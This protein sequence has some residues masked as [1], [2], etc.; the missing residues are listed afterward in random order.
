MDE[1]EDNKIDFFSPGTVIAFVCAFIGDLGFILIVP[2]YVMGVV[3]LAILLPQSRGFLAKLVL[4][5]VFILP[6]PTLFLGSMLAVVLSNKFLRFVAEQAA[7]VAVTVA[8]GGAGAAAEGAVAAEEAG[9]VAATVGEEAAEGAAAAGRAGEAARA[10]EGAGEAGEEAAEETETAADK[11]RKVSN[12]INDNDQLPDEEN[13][14]DEDEMADRNEGN[15]VDYL[16]EDLLERAQPIE[17]N[18]QENES[19]SENSD[20]KNKTVD[21]V[22]KGINLINNSDSL[23]KDKKEDDSDKEWPL[24]A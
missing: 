17:N 18:R 19:I 14:T 12:Y 22:K 20:Q 6:L 7:I 21:N 23:N 11:V 16:Q 3:V 24:A 8:T 15:P 13:E 4:F 5:S 10:A 9:E 2:H 1:E